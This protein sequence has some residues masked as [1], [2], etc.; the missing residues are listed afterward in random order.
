MQTKLGKIEYWCTN[1]CENGYP[2]EFES[3]LEAEL[4][5]R[6]KKHKIKY[7]ITCEWS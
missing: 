4:H 5:Q 1:C 7:R 6:R 3:F 2:K